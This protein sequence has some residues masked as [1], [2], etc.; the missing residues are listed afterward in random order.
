MIDLENI[1]KSLEERGERLS[2][3][4]PMSIRQFSWQLHKLIFKI[5]IFAGVVAWAASHG[6]S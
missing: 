6:H 1:G 3:V 5:A 4:K 2:T